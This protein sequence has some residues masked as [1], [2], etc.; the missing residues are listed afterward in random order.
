MRVSGT[1]EI[2]TASEVIEVP[3]ELETR[4]QIDYKETKTMY[5]K[6]WTEFQSRFVFEMDTKYSISIDQFQRASK[7]WT[8]RE[9][10]EQGMN[11]T[12][13]YLVNMLSPSIKQTLCVMLDTEERPTNWEDIANE[14]FFIINGQHTV[15]A[16]MKIQTLGLS[17]KLVESLLHWN[18]FIVWFN[19]DKNRRMQ[20]LRYYN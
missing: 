5:K 1:I 20:I 19:K 16:S 15:G 9:Y 14:T 2:S 8:I 18:C 12:L 13:H 4:G 11:E 3:S 17:P 6:F 10:K 7:D